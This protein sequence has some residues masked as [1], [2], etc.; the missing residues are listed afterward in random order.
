MVNLPGQ[1]EHE[2]LMCMDSNLE[3]LQSDANS[4]P[5]PPQEVWTTGVELLAKVDSPGRI[6]S[7]LSAQLHV[8]QLGMLAGSSTE[9]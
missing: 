9:T 6:K 8:V 7:I 4:P 3:E 1:E 2:T 5:F